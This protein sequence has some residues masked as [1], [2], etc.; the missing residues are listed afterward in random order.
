MPSLLTLGV[1]R[2]VRVAMETPAR[3][4][5]ALFAGNTANAALHHSLR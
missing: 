1:L 3:A 4:S 5:L 2:L